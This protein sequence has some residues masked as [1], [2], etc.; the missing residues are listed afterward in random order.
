MINGELLKAKIRAERFSLDQAA[1]KIGMFPSTFYRKLAGREH[2][3]YV[4]EAR[5]LAQ[6]AKLSRK[7][8]YDIFFADKPADVRK[9]SHEV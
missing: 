5:E 9:E 2:S 7:E 3:F 6:M 1:E 8:I 4:E